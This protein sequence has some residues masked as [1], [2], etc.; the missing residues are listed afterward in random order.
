MVLIR[1]NVHSPQIL[2]Q[3]SERFSVFSKNTSLNAIY[4]PSYFHLTIIT[5]PNACTHSHKQPKVRPL[6]SNH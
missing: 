3:L 2:P 6:Y 4:P 1:K 5:F